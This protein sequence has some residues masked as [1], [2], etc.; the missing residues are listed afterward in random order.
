ML[1][2]LPALNPSGRLRTALFYISGGGGR[3]WLDGVDQGLTAS[4]TSPAGVS[5]F[6]LSGAGAGGGGGGGQATAG[7]GGGGGGAGMSVRDVPLIVIPGSTWTVTPGTAG[8]GGA[9]GVAGTAGTNTIISCTGL[10][11]AGAGMGLGGGTPLPGS[12]LPD[13]QIWPGNG[14]APGSGGNGGA[15]GGASYGN[16]GGG[17]GGAGANGG[18]GSFQGTD[19]RFFLGGGGTG[20]GAANFNGASVLNNSNGAILPGVANSATTGTA[21]NGGGGNGGNT[22]FSAIGTLGRGGIASTASTPLRGHW[23]GGGGGGYGGVAGADGGHGFVLLTW[24]SPW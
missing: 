4:W 12:P 17:V 22:L 3:L 13:L 8:T 5:N 21:T 19:P 2:M 7:G 11:F 6:M 16:V 18:Q 23:G 10:L 14:G 15:G 9:P 20:G 1:A 24:Q